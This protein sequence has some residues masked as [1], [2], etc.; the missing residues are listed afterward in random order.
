MAFVSDQIGLS[1]P[2]F[3]LQQLPEQVM[4]AI[5]LTAAVERDHQQIPAL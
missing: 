1:S 2:E 5:P 4:V 3:R